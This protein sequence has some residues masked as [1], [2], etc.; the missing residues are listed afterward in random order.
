MMRR[1]RQ[2]DLDL[3][4]LA[5]VSGSAQPH[6]SVYLN[7]RATR[8]RG[9]VEPGRPLAGRA[10]PLLSREV[11]PIWM[12]SS[13]STECAEIERAVGGDRTLAERTGSRAFER[14]TA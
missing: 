8:A 9:T 5:A 12:D 3:R 6:G 7:H 10:E 14:F 4:Q 1:L 11:A 13:T 2:S